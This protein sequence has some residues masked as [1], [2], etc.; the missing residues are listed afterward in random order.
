MAEDVDGAIEGAMEGAMDGVDRGGCLC[1]TA[2]FVNRT[3][4]TTN[5]GV[6]LGVILIGVE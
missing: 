6:V 2:P 4:F 1:S 5:G 3:P